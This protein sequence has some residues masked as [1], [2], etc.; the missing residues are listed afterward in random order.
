MGERVLVAVDSHSTSDASLMYGIDLAARMG[1]PLLLII[2]S[3]RSSS[4]SRGSMASP[5]D[6]DV[7]RDGWMDRAVEVTQQRGICMEM[8]VAVGRFLDE[9]TRF[10]RSQPAVQFIVIAA[11]EGRQGKAGG[12]FA[13]ALR[14]LCHEFEGEISLVEKAGQVIQFSDLYLQRSFQETQE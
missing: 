8:F 13:S 7:G 2:V 11:P 9:V 1:S 6:L 4:E 12:G 3:T 14:K 10:L 5:Q